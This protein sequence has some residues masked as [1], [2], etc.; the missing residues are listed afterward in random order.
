M[1]N[2]TSRRRFLGTTVAGAAMA[3][4]AVATSARAQDDGFTYE[5]TRSE[6]EWR[7]MFNDFEYRILREGNTEPQYTSPLARQ[8]EDGV[9]NCRGCDL[10]LYSS[11]WRE[12]PDK[13]WVF[14]RH[15]QPD[16]M[17]MSIDG[18]QEAYGQMGLESL[19][20]IE[21]HCRR[22]GS[23][24]GHILLVNNKIL[25]CLNGCALDFVPAQA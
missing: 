9:F 14:F 16:A 22:C 6:A 5:V 7:E 1:S 8:F 15:A 25:H 21:V 13:G 17:L 18:P 20:N 4:L 3:P 24:I 11:R 19:T 10:E 23:H 2:P 12:D